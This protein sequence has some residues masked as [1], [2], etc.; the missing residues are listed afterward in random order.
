VG[1]EFTLYDQEVN[2][3]LL[4]TILAPSTGF[5]S[6]VGNV[7]T[8]TNSG[9]ELLLRASPIWN[10]KVQWNITATYSSNENEVTDIAGSERIGLANSF[11]TSYVIEGE[12]LGVFY[13][14]SYERDASGEIVNTGTYPYFKN[15]GNAI[16][17]DPNP[18]WFGSL[19]NEVTV[20]D[21]SFRVQLDAVQGQD[22]FNWNRRLLNNLLFGGGPGVGAELRGDLPKRTG[23]GQAGIFEEFVE[24]GSFIKLRELAITYNLRKPIKGVDNLQLSLVG[25]NLIS[26]DDYQAWDPEIN[27]TGQNNGVRGFDFAGVPIPRTIQLGINFTL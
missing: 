26:W 14:A 10:K 4:S 1:I 23:G 22:V 20:G 27:T 15:G 19:I 17:G 12:P 11:A 25:R 21:F 3:L 5:S 9:V 18:E 24:D 7:G 6:A 8:L 13:R 16:I 2:D